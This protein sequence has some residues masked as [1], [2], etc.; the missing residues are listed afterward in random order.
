M[1]TASIGAFLAQPRWA[2][3]CV[4]DEAGDLVASPVAIRAADGDTL[5]MTIPDALTAALTAAEAVP[6]ALTADESETYEGIVGVILRGRLRA[7][8]GGRGRF[9][10]DHAAGFS[11]AGTLPPELQR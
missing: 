11:F 2:A 8:G 1:D 7:G 3:A 4:V 10:I 9:T 6:A 5:D